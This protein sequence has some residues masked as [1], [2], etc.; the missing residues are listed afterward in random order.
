M[1]APEHYAWRLCFVQEGGWAWF[2]NVEPTE[3]WGDDWDDAPHHCNAGMPY[4]KEGQELLKVAFDGDLELMGVNHLARW[5]WLS[6]QDLN[7]RKAPWL[8]Q[9]LYGHRP[10][11]DGGDIPLGVQVW[12][13][14][15]LVEFVRLVGVAGGHVYLPIDSMLPA[16]TA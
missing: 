1:T 8:A 9:V 11:D 4:G 14:T 12:A 2:A 13:G 10:L 6:A 3:V 15:V 5:G 7:A 16:V